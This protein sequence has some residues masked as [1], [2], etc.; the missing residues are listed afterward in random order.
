MVTVGEK[1]TH[2]RRLHDSG[3]F[4]M[5]NAW[6]RGSATRLAKFGFPAIAST[7]AGAAWALGKNDGG[8][9]LDEVLSHLA[10]LVEAVDVPVNADFENGFADSPQAVGANVGR[11]VATGVAGISIEDWSGEM[12]YEQGL[13]VDRIAAAR[14]AIDAAAPG[15]MLI[16]RSEHFRA[17][18]LS[19]EECIRR[20]AA[21]AGA[22]AD[23][24][25]VPMIV[26]P[27]A[28]RELVAAV[29]PK[30]VSVLLPSLDADP[31]YFASLGVRR[32]S[33]GALLPSMAWRAFE[34]A[35]QALS[36]KAPAVN[37]Y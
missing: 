18:G 25:F 31:H 36:D 9:T 12:L 22:G 34:T 29:A 20:A 2:F 1:R 27:A 5:P 30:P 6:D 4:V 26:D 35:A 13:A 16:G 7:S 23:C 33:T 21:Y 37:G 32:C 14:Q 19:V 17:P 28:L 24:L 11:A 10:Q 15:V 8:L 3:F